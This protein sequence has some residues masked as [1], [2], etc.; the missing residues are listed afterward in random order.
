MF[1]NL[2]GAPISMST[3]YFLDG[4]YERYGVPMNLPPP[5]RSL[6]E[7]HIDIEIVINL[8]FLY[9]YNYRMEK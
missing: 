8:T 4:D 2:L 1:K 5:D 7:T 6:H 9:I 3:P